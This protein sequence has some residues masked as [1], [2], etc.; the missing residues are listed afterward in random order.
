MTHLRVVT[1]GGWAW[2]QGE[3]MF[4]KDIHDI[5]AYLSSLKP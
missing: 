4:D 2:F 5:A 1:D 3:G